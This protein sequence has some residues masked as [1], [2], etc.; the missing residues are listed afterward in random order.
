ML[1]LYWSL[2]QLQIFNSWRINPRAVTC[3]S[4]SFNGFMLL[5]WA[6]LWQTTKAGKQIHIFHEKVCVELDCHKFPRAVLVF[7]RAVSFK[8]VFLIIH[9]HYWTNME[10]TD[11]NYSRGGNIWRRIEGRMIPLIEKTCRDFYLEVVGL[12]SWSDTWFLVNLGGLSGKLTSSHK[13]RCGYYKE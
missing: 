3:Y 9:N 4:L 1:P 6:H 8:E 10:T 2:L 5:H 7:S 11:G 13:G 12:L